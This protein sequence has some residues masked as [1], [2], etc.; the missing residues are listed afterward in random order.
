MTEKTTVKKTVIMAGILLTT[1]VGCQ[2][3]TLNN[4]NST[5]ALLIPIEFEFVQST[6]HPC[7]RIGLDFGEETKEFS[8]KVSHAEGNTFEGYALIQDIEPGNYT[9]D[10]F[11]CHPHRGRIFNGAQR[12]ITKSTNLT[13]NIK[14]DELLVTKNTLAGSNKRINDETSFYIKFAN[15]G[16][17]SQDKAL[18]KLNENP[19]PE[20]WSIVKD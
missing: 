8:V 20:G 4:T 17:D 18:A 5:G 16:S 14:Q 1:L 9:I 15:Y 7:N 2:S 13:F 11:Y 10:K 19:I 12:Y 6:R 3:T